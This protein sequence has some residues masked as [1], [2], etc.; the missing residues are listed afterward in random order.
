MPSGEAS[1]RRRA[2]AHRGRVAA[3]A[4]VGARAGGVRRRSA[5][6]K[7]LPEPPARARLQRDD[8]LG[9]LGVFLLVFLS[10]FP[11]VIPF[12]V[13]NERAGPARLER[14]RGRPVLRGGFVWADHRA[15][16]GGCSG[17]DGR[18]GSVLVGLTIALGA[19]GDT[20]LRTGALTILGALSA[21]GALA[22]EAQ[23]S[24]PPAPAEE[25]RPTG[26]PGKG[27]WTFNL[28]VGLGG[29]GF[30]ELSLHQRSARSLR[31]PERQLGGELRQAGGLGRFGVGGSELYGKISAVGERTFAAPPLAR[32]RVA[33]RRSR[34]KTSPWLALGH[35]P[36]S[37]ENL[38]DLTVGRTQYT[39]GDGFSSGT[40]P[41][42]EVAAAA[43]GATPESLG[44]R[45]GRPAKAGNHTFEVFYL[46]RDELPES[47]TGT[48]L[49]GANYEL[50]RGRDIDLRR[51]YLK[52]Y[53][54]RRRARP[55][56]AERL[57]R[58]GVHSP[59]PAAARPLLRARVC[60]GGE[61]RRLALMP[62]RARGLRDDATSPGSRS[63]PTAMPPSRA[64]TRRPPRTRASIRSCP[65]SPT[66]ARGGRARSP[67][68]TSSRTST[69]SRTRCGCTWRRASRSEPVSS[70]SVPGRRGRRIRPRR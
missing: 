50:G 53:A 33:P 24:P 63:P 12:L 23:P 3:G 7:Q 47:E 8:W 18:A 10:T 61:R 34:S 22:Q 54:D 48:R 14:H 46:D 6:L 56:R 40:G 45:G 25:E 20:V 26:L 17:R 9:A 30:A 13:M 19:D 39:I 4:G 36:G 51:D 5:R 59:F 62:S 65:A 57:Q 66:G 43:T 1:R 29:F 52:L 21:V 2:A 67:A 68:S 44:V 58:A 37:S 16:P 32:R 42:R 49:W 27:P 11:V 38:L 41:A 31:R 15:P 35:V 60:A 55:G 64:T 70:S 28:D 69:W